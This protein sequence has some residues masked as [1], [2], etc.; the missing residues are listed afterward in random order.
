MTN[1]TIP[2]AQNLNLG[3]IYYILFR[4]KWKI[5]LCSLAGIGIGVAL[6]KTESPP[7]QSEAMLL[8]R[9]I[10]TPNTP[11]APNPNGQ[12]TNGVKSAD[13]RGA[14]I[15][16]TEMTILNS[17]DLAKVVAEIY[18]PEKILAKT[19][20]GK[21]L[22]AAT[23]AVHNGLRVVVPQSSTVLQLT[24]RHPDPDLVQPLLQVIIEQ[25]LKKHLEIHGA[26]GLL[27]EQQQQAM[28][29]TQLRLNQAEDELRRALTAIGVT[30]IENAKEA[31]AGQMA[32]N[33]RE[34]MSY[35]TEVAGRIA[36]LEELKKRL[37]TSKTP[38]PEAP[39]EP[40]IPQKIIDDHKIL[41]MRVGRLQQL[42]QE[43]LAQFTP[44]TIR[45]KLAQ[46]QLA[47]AEVALN[48]L[49]EQYPQLVKSIRQ[50][51]VI[52]P[53]MDASE[54]SSIVVQ[55]AAYKAKIK[56]LDTQYERLRAE[57]GKY[58]RAEANI[59]DLKR[60]R[61]AAFAAYTTVNQ[62]TETNRFNREIG[63][64]GKVA[65]INTV[66]SPSP[67][68]R[69]PIN[70]RRSALFAVA[71]IIAGLA[72]A[73]LVELYLDRSVRRPQD[74]T[75]MLRAPLFLTIPRL[76]LD[77]QP[78][79]L[80]ATAKPAD[81]AA[82]TSTELVPAKPAKRRRRTHSLQPFHETLRDR[83]IGYFESRNL[84]HKPKLV[85]VTGLGHEAGVTTTAAGLARSLSETGEGNVLLVDMTVGEGAAKHFVKGR[86]A[87]GLDELLEARSQG[88]VQDNLYVVTE[89]NNS[90][91]LSR[92]MPQ[93]FARLIPKLKASDFDYIIFDMPPVSQLSI[94]PRL[95]GYMDMV[96]LVVESESTDR[97]LVQGACNLLAESKAHVG[98]V[99]NKTRNYVPGK[100]SPELLAT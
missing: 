97:D 76:K 68:F 15:M 17:A 34:V 24:F 79:A 23:A 86:E 9:Y 48:K 65:N 84:T 93:R 2:A 28:D 32:S 51:R 7:F 67:S 100:L 99:L 54:A 13:E 5:L 80:E 71:G 22:G 31:V 52:G 83:L 45:V 25:Y 27:S 87:C 70:V 85:A 33:R 77:P 47:E 8:V 73:F 29:S 91:R 11:S 18:G 53:D 74:L 35:E 98:V 26:G 14:T 88:H 81:G 82:S 92:N 64:I 37:E 56:E 62:I 6:Y 4:H 90:E 96:L 61:D 69:E 89:N 41:T 3:D 60:K 94:T 63:A 55:I 72:W 44:E 10:V 46:S 36:I 16:N 12:N 75:R 38:P 95:A 66:Q 43:L 40:E 30:S 50:D 57:A 1:Q 58:E 42:E 78:L 49:R 39:K 21:D 19:G 20:G 59:Q